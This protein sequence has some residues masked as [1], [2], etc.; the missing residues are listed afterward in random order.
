MAVPISGDAHLEVELPPKFQ[1]SEHK[2][3]TNFWAEYLGMES[4]SKHSMKFQLEA[5]YM[6]RSDFT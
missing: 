5:I 1:G 3:R 4:P 6:L 2:G